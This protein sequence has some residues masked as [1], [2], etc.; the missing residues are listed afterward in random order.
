MDNTRNWYFL[1]W[2]VRGISSQEKWDNIR[3]KIRE[4]SPHIFSLQETKREAFDR[5]YV[6][7]FCPRHLSE[8][9]FSPSRGA[10]GGLITVWNPN[11]FRGEMVQVNQYSI[12][13]KFSPLANGKS[14]HHTSICGPSSPDEKDSFIN[15]LYNFDCSEIEDWVIMGDFN[16]I[17]SPENRNRSGGNHNDMMLF[18]DVI[19]HL[20]LV[21][22]AF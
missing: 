19:N 21:D 13:I 1:S 3:D 16:L 18:N 8:F 4:L 17:R 14:F 10:S 9:V 2:N 12:T 5:A 11:Q 20:D 22:I 6:K 15:W 7:K